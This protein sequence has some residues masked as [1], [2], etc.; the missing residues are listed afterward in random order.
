[1]KCYVIEVYL[2]KTDEYPFIVYN[3]SCD[4][5][6]KKFL[7]VFDDDIHITVTNPNGNTIKAKDYLF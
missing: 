1:M 5:E 4:T 6:V 7:S 3:A 2:E